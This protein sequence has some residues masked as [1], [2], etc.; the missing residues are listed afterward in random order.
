MHDKINLNHFDCSQVEFLSGFDSELLHINYDDC[1]GARLESNLTRPEKHEGKRRESAEK[2]KRNE[3][4]GLLFSFVKTIQE[5]SLLAHI[6]HMNARRTACKVLRCEKSAFPSAS[7][8]FRP[9]VTVNLWGAEK[10]TA[11]ARGLRSHKSFPK[12]SQPTL[13][14]KD[15]T[16]TF[17]STLESSYLKVLRC[18]Q[19]SDQAAPFRI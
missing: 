7:F 10:V 13:R 5:H 1:F 9:S 12:A 19:G 4:W 17:H 6:L 11:H 2:K 16:K 15:K 8:T 18:S 3:R 14:L